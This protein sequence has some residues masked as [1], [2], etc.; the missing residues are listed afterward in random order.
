MY[1]NWITLL[2]WISLL[3]CTDT[4]N[5]DGTLVCGP[6]ANSTRL[7]RRSSSFVVK[8]I[9]YT[10]KTFKVNFYLSMVIYVTNK[11]AFILTDN[12]QTMIK[13]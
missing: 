1:E 6:R 13:M 3:V 2:K 8:D 5:Q 12:N 10:S 7:G 4:T 9:T 11:R